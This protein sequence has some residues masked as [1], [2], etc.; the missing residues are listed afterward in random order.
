MEEWRELFECYALMLLAIHKL[1][2][3]R[4]DPEE[5]NLLSVAVICNTSKLL[6]Y[7][8]ANEIDEALAH[9][10][11]IMDLHEQIYGKE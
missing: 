9:L 7:V 8:Q 3:E 11:T 4:K 10:D 2:L 1:S 6:Q 5:K